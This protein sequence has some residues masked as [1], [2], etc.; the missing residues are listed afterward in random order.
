MAADGVDELLANLPHAA[1]FAPTIANLRGDGERLAFRPIDVDLA[2]T[3]RLL[4]AA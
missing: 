4:P 1:Y 2:W 3:I